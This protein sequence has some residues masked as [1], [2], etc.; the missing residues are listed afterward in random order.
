M[1][2][3][4]R[5]HEYALFARIS[6]T[7]RTSFR[8]EQYHWSRTR[9]A[10]PNQEIVPLSDKRSSGKSGRTRHPRA[11]WLQGRYYPCWSRSHPGDVGLHS[12]TGLGSLAPPHFANTTIAASRVDVHCSNSTSGEYLHECSGERWPELQLTQRRQIEVFVEVFVLF[13]QISLQDGLRSVALANS[14]PPNNGVGLGELNGQNSYRHRL[15][16]SIPHENRH[17]DTRSAGTSSVSQIVPAAAARRPFTPATT[18][19]KL[20]KVPSAPRRTAPPCGACG[21]T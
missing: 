15:F 1:C 2:G 13:V 7:P 20:S 4:V 21:L 11:S 16:G 12:I 9:Q 18:W 5:P 3:A 19:L 8:W 6:P 17:Q 10:R 14:G